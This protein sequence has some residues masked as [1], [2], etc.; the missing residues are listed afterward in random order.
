MAIAQPKPKPPVTGPAPVTIA[1]MDYHTVVADVTTTPVS[2]MLTYVEGSNWTC[3]YYSQVLGLSDA[4]SPLQLELAPAYQQYNCVEGLILKV[5]TALSTSQ[6]QESRQ[7][8]V[9]G[10]ATVFPFVIPNVGDMFVA[11]VGDGRTGLFT[12]TVAEKKTILKETCYQIDYGLV[13]ILNATYADNLADKTIRTVYFRADRSSVELNPL[14]VSADVAT[15]ESAKALRTRLLAE[16]LAEF[17]NIEVQTLAVPEQT[18]RVYD[19]Y[20]VELLLKITTVSEH[21]LLR[22]IKQINTD[23]TALDAPLTVVDALVNFS[24]AY[25]TGSFSHV[26]LASVA[27]FEWRPMLEGIRYSGFDAVVYPY[28]N[29]QYTAQQLHQ[30]PLITLLHRQ[31][32]VPT[33]TSYTGVGVDDHYWLSDAFYQGGTDGTLLELLVRRLFNDTEIAYADVVT[34]IDTLK[35]GAPIDRY[36]YLPLILMILN[37]IAV[38]L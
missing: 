28:G 18:T 3:N 9:T 16:Y 13:D 29:A 1:P 4:L 37:Y 7:F 32:A 23:G 27:G 21:P 36:Y 8:T 38:K 6:D 14:L 2:S 25:L 11:D 31:S 22:K 12:V 17:Y 33:H 20:V 26:R 35:V 5:N 34:V 19:P 24:Q 10:Q 15:L 30:P